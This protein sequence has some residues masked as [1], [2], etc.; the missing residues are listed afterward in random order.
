MKGA[1][2]TKQTNKSNSRKNKKLC[3]KGKVIT[4]YY[5]VTINT[6]SRVKRLKDGKCR[7][8]AMGE[9]NSNSHLWPR[10]NNKDQICS[11]DCNNKK[12]D[13]IYKMVLKIPDIRELKTVIPVSQEIREVSPMV[14]FPGYSTEKG[15]CQTPKDSRS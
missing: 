8:V 15:N 9:L 1:Q 3:R 5:T 11:P 13:E 10:W 2:K 12:L 6:D 4:I 7:R 14:E